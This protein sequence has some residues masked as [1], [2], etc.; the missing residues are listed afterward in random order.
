MPLNQLKGKNDHKNDFMISLLIS[1]AAELGFHLVFPHWASD[2]LWTVLCIYTHIKTKHIWSGK[3]FDSL[4]WTPETAHCM[5][6]FVSCMPKLCMQKLFFLE[7]QCLY[8]KKY[9]F[10]G[11]NYTKIETLT[12]GGNH[13]KILEILLCTCKSFSLISVSRSLISIGRF[14]ITEM[15]KKKF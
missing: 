3:R 15:K 4:P 14:S 6:A 2:V 8:K 12:K 13:E 9:M 5:Y 11:G 7:S 1:Y 10:K